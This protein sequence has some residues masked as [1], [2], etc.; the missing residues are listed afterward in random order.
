MNLDLNQPL[1]EG[2][3]F[4]QSNLQDFV[5]CSRRFYLKHILR[6]AWPAPLAEPQSDI[7]K[8][9]QRGSRFHTLAERHQLDISWENILKSC[10]DDPIL[11][12]WLRQYQNY[13]QKLGTFDKK[14]SETILSTAIGDYPLMAKY[15]F[16]ILQ[17]NNLIALDWKT[18]VLPSSDRLRQRMQSLVY[19]YVLFR[20]GERLAQKRLTMLQ[21]RYFSVVNG[22]EVEFT[23]T[24]S[25]I[26]TIEQT[27]LNHI[28]AIHQSDFAKVVDETPCRYCVYRG[29]CERGTTLQLPI[30]EILDIENLWDNIATI[31]EDTIEF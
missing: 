12:T 11:Q 6:Q 13:L 15:D 5:D 22:A 19:S 1:P 20:Q 7:E 31:S 28:A 27:L 9:M 25:H 29:L 4:S 21:L 3:Q 2:F 23:I 24:E 26:P 18:G 17:G 30:D 8:A 14:W 10:A 16:I